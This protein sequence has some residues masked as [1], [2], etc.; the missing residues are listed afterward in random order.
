MLQSKQLP[1]FHSAVLLLIGSTLILP[2]QS[3]R[4][5]LAH[6]LPPD[7][8]RCNGQN[9][10]LAV[11]AAKPGLSWKLKASSPALHSASQTAY[12]I[13]VAQTASDLATSRKLVWDSGVIHS[14]ETRGIPYAGPTLSAQSTYVWKVRVW[15]EQGHPSAWSR[16][17]HW[18]Q[19][20]EW[21]AKWIGAKADD[22]NSQRDAM[23]LFRKSFT[24]DS[25]IRRALIYASG[26]GQDE[27]HLNGKKVSDDQLTPGWSEYRKT[28]YFDTYDVT[29]LLHKGEN[30][31]GILLGNGMYRVLKTEGRYTKF[32]GSYGPLKCILQ[33]HIEFADGQKLEVSSDETWKTAPGPVTFSSTYGGE[34]FDARRDPQGWD[35]PGFNDAAWQAAKV[36]D[37]PGGVLLPDLPPPI[38]VIKTYAPGQPTRPRPGLLVYDLGQ[39]FAGWPAITVTG[40]AGAVVKLTPGELLNKDGTVSQRSSGEPQ[41]FSYTLRGSK[42]AENWHPR[43]SYYGFRYVQ[44]EGADTHPTPGA[45]Q[46]LVLR[47]EA[48]HSSSSVAGSFSSS[49]PLLNKIHTLILRA[50]ENN[51][52]SLFTDCPH[53]EKLGWLEESHLLASAMLYDFDFARLYAATARNIADAQA[54]GG[55]MQ[56]NVPSTAP[57]YKMGRVPEIAPQYVLFEPQWGVFDDS[58]EWGSAAVLSPWY[59]YQRNGDLQFLAE[60]YEVMRLY[61]GYLGTRAKDG[62]I[63]YGLGDWYDIGPGEPG[64]SKLTTS[65]VTATATY[66]Q[67]LRVMERTAALLGKNDESRQFAQLADA[68]RDRFNARFFDS[69]AHRYD[70]GSQTAQAMPLVVGL[71]PDSE[72]AAVLNALVKDIR[73]HNNHV[74]AGDI[75]FHYVVDALLDGGRS[76]VLLE[77]LERTD[78]PS[79]GY[80]LAQGATALTEAW[81][82]DPESSQDHF[83][84]G[85]AEEW[86]YRGLGGI[87]IDSS[88]RGDERLVLRPQVV[89]TLAWVKTSYQSNKGLV[90]SAWQRGPVDTDYDFTIP[91]NSNATIEIFSTPGDGLTL[92]GL[93]ATKAQGVISSTQIDSNTH[94]VVSAG[95]YRIR[96]AS[97]SSH[98]N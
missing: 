20:P 22:A 15:D 18:T 14:A 23:P 53:R 17:A 73:A 13:Q 44:V 94:I 63:A 91:V 43:F 45:A 79:Y 98:S 7:D 76:D 4:S 56:G 96:S 1:G 87:N 84:L 61:T 60:Q 36:V 33:L 59:V 55:P 38:R 97:P 71:V 62:I 28:V 51:S 70:R 30:A 92:N 88:L 47:G 65:G 21:H 58:P 32:T 77:M 29:S 5:S 37:G 25:P 82:A 19:T 86:F 35:R 78:S 83:M 11:A 66:Y 16:P 34:D 26:L 85:H 46:I 40:P 27:L 49:D 24:V 81:D 8:L 12:Q 54:T 69:A 48:I 52:V 89:G 9:E 67:D 6:L 64:I 74:T 68:T 72:R 42:S 57:P 3:S 80:Q 75:G 39:N 10:P 50:I 31:I 95:H 90:E 93:P 41:W 2:A